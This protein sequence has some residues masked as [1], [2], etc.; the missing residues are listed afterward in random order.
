MTSALCANAAAAGEMLA[1]KMEPAFPFASSSRI[2]DNPKRVEE[3][4][5]RGVSSGVDAIFLF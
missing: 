3:L 5:R 4:L 2:D 1:P